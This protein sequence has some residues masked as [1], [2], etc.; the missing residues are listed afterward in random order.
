MEHTSVEI[1]LW[2][3]YNNFGEHFYLM[4]FV[5]VVIVDS[6]IVFLSHQS[7]K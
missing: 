1:S 5:D 7:W 6:S 4:G 3:N 2:R